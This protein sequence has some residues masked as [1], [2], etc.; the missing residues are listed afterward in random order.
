MSDNIGVH[1]D[2]E[3]ERIGREVAVGE[4]QLEVKLSGRFRDR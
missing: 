3:G 4:R 1:V 2:R